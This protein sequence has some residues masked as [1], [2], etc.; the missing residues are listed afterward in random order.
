MV[1][2]AV[3]RVVLMRGLIVRMLRRGTAAPRA[4]SRPLVHALPPILSR[5]VLAP[6]TA[7]T[8]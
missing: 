5:R 1:R 6:C 3:G 2:H 8:R 7:A 4:L